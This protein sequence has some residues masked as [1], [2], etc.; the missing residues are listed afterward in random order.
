MCISSSL[1]NVAAPYNNYKVF[2]MKRKSKRKQNR[3]QINTDLGLGWYRP[4]QW[5]RLR[6]ISADREALHDTYA[7]WL[8]E[9]NAS[10]QKWRRMGMHVR[11]V[12][13]DVDELL[14]W[15]IAR[16]LKVDAAAR[17]RFVTEKVVR[18]SDASRD[19]RLARVV[20]QNPRSEVD[21]GRSG[22][23]LKSAS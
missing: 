17:S 20:E 11:P 9:A 7:A 16:Q 13:I 1:V 18:T 19:Q 4:E 12:E 21:S 5:Q 3:S 10:L 22:E 2:I 14:A 6:E 15:C 8:H 23:N